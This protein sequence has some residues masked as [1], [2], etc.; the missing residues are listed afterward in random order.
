MTSNLTSPY[1][2]SA[3]YNLAQYCSASSF[4][5]F[6]TILNS[7]L[8]SNKVISGRNER[9]KSVDPEKVYDFVVIGGKSI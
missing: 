8:E 6:A 4:V 5:T 3:D 1:T 2:Y 9:V 7:L